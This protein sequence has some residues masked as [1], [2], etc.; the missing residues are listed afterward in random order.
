MKIVVLGGGESGVGAAYLAKKK[1]LNVFLSDKGVIK[2]EYKKQ[3]IDAEIE[4]EEGKHDEARILKADW[5]IKS[6]GIP[7]KAEIIYKIN[8]KGIRLSSE[9][10][11]AAEFTTAK[12]IAITGSNGKTTTTSLIYHILKNDD[13]KVGLAGNIGKSFAR[14]V[15]DENF[16]YYVLEVS[17]FQLDDI[18]NFRPF[19][20]LLLNLSKD[21]LDQYNYNYDEYALAKFRIAENQENDNFFIYNKD[22][23]MSM[24]ILE[25]LAINATKIPFSTHEKLP[26][27]GFINKDKIVVKIEEEFSMKIA[28]LALVGNH[29]IANSLA[30]SIA[31]KILH[32]SNESIR[33]SLMTFQAVEHRLEQAAKINGVT[34]I[35]DSKATNVNASYFAL[36]SMNQP[37]V[38]I[39]GGV[40]KGNDY[41]EIEDLVK[42]KVKAIVCLGID[43]QKII[44]FF[45]DKKDLIYSTSS[46]AEAIKVSKSL[47]TEGDTVLLSPCCASFDLFDNYEDRGNQFKSEVLKNNEKILN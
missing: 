9:I 35:N 46:M 41:T 33:N 45:K 17:S 36:E 47:A 44:D 13:L 5:V 42:R 26:E 18:Q 32:I 12:I 2:D 23:E 43:N 29:N 19:I 27:G 10:E 14:Q 3:L 30:A 24:K 6:P 38:W 39:V 16:D 34:F 1:G 25:K 20:S 15:A 8:Q 28:E 11:F 22:D 21:H 40:D 31:S 4:F 37:T 7:K